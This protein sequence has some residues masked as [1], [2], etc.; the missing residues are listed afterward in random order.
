M[1]LL[2][3]SETGAA[4][5]RKRYPPAK[6]CRPGAL[7]GLSQNVAEGSERNLFIL[8]GRLRLL[9]VLLSLCY[10]LF[11]VLDNTEQ[12]NIMTNYILTCVHSFVDPAE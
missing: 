8:R 2:H 6:N 7:S 12:S 3:V 1:A 11:F 4:L 9:Y 5:A 10:Q